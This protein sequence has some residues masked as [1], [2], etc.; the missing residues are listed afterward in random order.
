MAWCCWRLYSSWTGLRSRSHIGEEA[1]TQKASKVQIKYST[2]SPEYILAMFISVN[3]VFSSC[4]YFRQKA[5]HKCFGLKHHKRDWI[6]PKVLGFWFTWFF[7]YKHHWK[8][9]E[10]LLK[11]VK[12]HSSLQRWNTISYCCHWLGRILTS[13]R[14]RFK[15]TKTNSYKAMKGLLE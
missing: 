9:T 4:F 3:R 7:C 11:N 2:H 12:W 13:V 1:D 5:Q 6:C 8:M 15:L 14:V 10:G